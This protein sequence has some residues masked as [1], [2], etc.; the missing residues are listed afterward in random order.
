[1]NLHEHCFTEITILL[2]ALLKHM[3]Y[4]YEILMVDIRT[5]IIIIKKK[6]KNYKYIFE[7]IN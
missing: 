2:Y 3:L 4:Y 5:I 1:M 6:K 7:F